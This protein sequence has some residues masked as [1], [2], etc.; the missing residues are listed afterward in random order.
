MVE[1]WKIDENYIGQYAKYYKYIL[2]SD[3]RTVNKY[4]Y[5]AML[6]DAS[7][8]DGNNGKTLQPI[9]YYIRWIHS[10]E[11]HSLSYEKN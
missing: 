6:R 5:G 3:V 8:F 10:G 11:L 2:Q 1:T 4:K 9:S 7:R